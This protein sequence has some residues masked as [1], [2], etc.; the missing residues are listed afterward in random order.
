VFAGL[1]LSPGHQRELLK[2]RGY[3]QAAV[4]RSDARREAA[5]Y[6]VEARAPAIRE[7]QE[8]ARSRADADAAKQQR[9]ADQQLEARRAAAEDY[10]EMLIRTG[11]GRWRSIE[12]VLAANTGWGLLSECDPPAQVAELEVTDPGERDMERARELSAA[13]Q[14]DRVLVEARRASQGR[15]LS[16]YP[17]RGEVLAWCANQPIF[18]WR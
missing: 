7:Q 15:A 2:A 4:E 11:Q 8:I 1:E 16:R 13:L 12:E 17:H 10:Q 3:D 18:Y 14:T 6:W 9:E 5:R